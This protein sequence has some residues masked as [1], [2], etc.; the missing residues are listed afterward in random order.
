MLRRLVDRL[1]VLLLP[2]RGHRRRRLLLLLPPLL[3]R[4]KPEAALLAEA[5]A[6]RR[7]DFR[8]LLLPSLW[9]RQLGGDSDDF[10]MCG[11]RLALLPP[12]WTLW[13][14]TTSYF[15]VLLLFLSLVL[16][17][18]PSSLARITWI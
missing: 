14:D 12:F 18:L 9:P 10:S 2:L 3:L 1:L 16:H 11:G 17:L 7:S 8:S 13:R 15:V 6:V 4:G 5:R